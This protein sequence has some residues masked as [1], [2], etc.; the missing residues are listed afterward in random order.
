M[1]DGYIYIHDRSARLDTYNCCLFDIANVFK[2]GFELGNI[3]Y[4]E[5]TTL[6]ICFNVLGDVIM[7][8]ASQQYGGFTVP[9]VDK[10]LEPY[11]IKSYNKYIKEYED[12]V[13]GL[14]GVNLSKEEFAKKADEYATHKVK[15]DFEQGFQALEY[16]LNTVGSSRGDYPFVTFTFPITFSS[17]FL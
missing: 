1:K 8:A 7:A 2:G 4:A 9:E 11:A 6:A 5:P 3:K 14:N 17:K 16:K 15:R 10:I 12:I 13:N